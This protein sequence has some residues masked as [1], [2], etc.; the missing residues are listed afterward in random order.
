MGAD[1]GRDAVGGGGLFCA[2]RG[3]DGLG[4]GGGEGKDFHG[5]E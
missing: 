5:R 2:E 1:Q 4:V 3:A